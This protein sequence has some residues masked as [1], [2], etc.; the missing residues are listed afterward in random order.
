MR[1]GAGPAAMDAVEFEQEGVLL[2]VADGIV[3]QDDLTACAS[4]DEVAQNEFSDAAE[5]VECDAGHGINLV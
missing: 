1:D 3:Q 2:G 5:A 4:V